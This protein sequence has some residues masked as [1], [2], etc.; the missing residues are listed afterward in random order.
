MD[1]QSPPLR[2]KRSRPNALRWCTVCRFPSIHRRGFGPPKTCASP[3][4]PRLPSRTRLHLSDQKAPSRY[5][6]SGMSCIG[7]FSTSAQISPLETLRRHYSPN[8]HHGSSDCKRCSAT[9]ALHLWSHSAKHLGP[10]PHC[11][12]H[13]LILAAAGFF[14]LAIRLRA[15]TRSLRSTPRCC[16]RIAHLSQVANRLPRAMTVSGSS[17]SRP[18][19]KAHAR[20]NTSPRTNY[21][22]TATN[23][24]TMRLLCASSLFNH[25]GLCLV[26]IT[27]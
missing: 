21:L 7:S 4:H 19:T 1:L 27:L 11:V 9:R 15:S 20:R 23:W 22:S 8:S 26:S 12:T 17:T 18:R 10:S 3:T 6:R 24:N 16:A 2:T 25:A 5:E 14:R 13:S